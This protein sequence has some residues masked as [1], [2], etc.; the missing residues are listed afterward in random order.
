MPARNRWQQGRFLVRGASSEDASA[1][2]E[3]IRKAFG[4]LLEAYPAA[5]E[6]ADA[7]RLALLLQT[8][9]KMLVA[10]DDRGAAG[11]VRWWREEGVAWFDLLASRRPFAGRT[12]VRA[13]ERLARDLGLRLCRAAVLEGSRAERAFS[14][15]G[16][17]PVQRRQERGRS[18]LVMERRL[19]LLTVREARREDAEVLSRLTGRDPWFFATMR[20]P[21]W[22]V[23]ADGDA[24]VGVCWVE[25]GGT[26]WS[27]GDLIVLPEHEGRGL[28]AWLLEWAAFYAATHG[29]ERLR[30]Q[31]SP[32]LERHAPEL[33]ARGWRPEADAFL[34]DLIASPPAIEAIT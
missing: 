12:L 25:R 33:E 22:Y 21:G 28:E 18:F 30:V 10:E 34:R 27:V 7:G 31:R 1:L 15:W 9:A 23:A 4:D 26:E 14:F 19:P 17:F 13:V 5:A 3:L 16:Y 32:L 2:A 24:V 8:G 11:T 29:A 20:P 6:A